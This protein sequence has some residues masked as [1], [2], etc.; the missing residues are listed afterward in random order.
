MMLCGAAAL[1]AI[2]V[3]AASLSAPS[4]CALTPGRDLPAATPAIDSREAMVAR[5]Q[6]LVQVLGNSYVR[7]GWK[8]DAARAAQFVECVRT[9]D[10]HDGECPKFVMV[11]DWMHDHGQSSDWL[12]DGDVGDMIATRA[13]VRAS[14]GTPIDAEL[15]ALGERL[16]AASAEADRLKPDCRLYDEAW[17]ASGFDRK[18]KARA[19]DAAWRRFEAKAKENGYSLA[20]KKWNAAAHMEDV[21]AKAILRIPSNS[22]IGDGVRA[23]AALMKEPEAQHEAADV[24]WDMAAR[25][26]FE[27]PSDIQKKL[28]RMAAA[29]ARKAV[30]S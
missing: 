2:T 5:A 4:E 15:I 27:P 16:K 24:L 7:E 21:L 11:R 30:Q 14:A 12:I 13:A 9:F 29:H 28:K 22:R 17:Q 3:P 20:S 26:G 25:A 8:L 10:E 23:F 1:P 18:L 6:Q 19:K